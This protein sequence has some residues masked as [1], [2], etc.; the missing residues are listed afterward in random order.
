MTPLNNMMI[1]NTIAGLILLMGINLHSQTDPLQELY[2]HEQEAL[3]QKS[4]N[5]DLVGDTTYDVK[6]YHI[7]VEIALDA[8]YIS[9]KV[10]YVVEATIDNFNELKL[11]LD[12]AFTIDSV[13]LVASGFSFTDNVLTITFSEIYNTG[14]TLSFGVYYSGAPVLAGGFKGLRYENHDGGQL[15]IA[16]L[17]TPY[18]AHTWWPCKDGTEDKAD[19]I[20]V[21][22]TIKDTLIAGIPVMGV[23]N[24]LL[25]DTESFDNKKKFKKIKCP[26]FI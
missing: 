3:Y 6:F 9:G 17:S 23:S 19:S 8:P 14:D 12:N 21:D 26:S 25:V 18:L 1:K 24:G 13:S 5:L 16:S 20:N 10:S 22:I 15:I 11:D 4:L 7:D 2:R